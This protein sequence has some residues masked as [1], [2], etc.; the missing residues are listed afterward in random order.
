MIKAL[1]MAS[2]GASCQCI[3][4]KQPAFSRWSCMPPTCQL[5]FIFPMA[6]INPITRGRNCQIIKA[7][8][9]TLKGTSCQCV[10]S[11]QL[12]FSR[13]SC[14]PPTCQLCFILPVAL[15]NPITRGRNCQTRKASTM[16]S[17][18]TSCQ[19]IK[20]KHPAFT[21]W[22][23]K[24]PSETFEGQFPVHITKYRK[25]LV[26]FHTM[27]QGFVLAIFIITS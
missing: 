5:W 12:V 8:K 7:S 23:F 27:S 9:I 2:K 11:K 24:L 15:H 13:W 16:A 26:V 1:T 14:I 3:I 19:C 18:G 6:F 22:S 21:R 10:T 20:S 25:I 4:S 17:K